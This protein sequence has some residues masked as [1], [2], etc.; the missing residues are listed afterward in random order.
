[1]STRPQGSA[2]MLKRPRKPHGSRLPKW[3]GSV[4]WKRRLLASGPRPPRSRG[5]G[6][7]PPKQT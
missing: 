7:G 2:S 3:T 1:M 4:H 6:L 5:S